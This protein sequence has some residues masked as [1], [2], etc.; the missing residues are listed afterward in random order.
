MAKTVCDL[1]NEFEDKRNAALM[2][3]AIEREIDDLE[4]DIF[5]HQC[6][7]NDLT[8]EN[9]ED[10]QRHNNRFVIMFK[11]DLEL[12]HLIYMDMPEGIEIYDNDWG[13]RIS[14]KGDNPEILNEC[15]DKVIATVKAAIANC[16]QTIDD[17]NG[18]RTS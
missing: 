10:I 14:I 3:A 16:Q 8:P 1:W 6:A 11:S 5:R 15:F 17:L 13:L 4:Y 2:D 12:Y 9:I 7:L 18:R